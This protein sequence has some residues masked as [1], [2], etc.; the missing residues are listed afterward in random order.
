MQQSAVGDLIERRSVRLRRRDPSREIFG[1]HRLSVEGHVREAIAVE[2]CGDSQE[3]AGAISGEIKLGG[4]AVH[5][6]DLA[7]ELRY[8]EDVENARGRQA[9]VHR[10]ADRCYET[11]DARDVLI[12]INEEPLPV[13][14]DDFYLERLH[15]GAQ[16]LGR[17]EL[18]R[19]D[20]RNAAKEEHD[21]CRYGP[22]EKLEPTR[23]GP[24]RRVGG[25][26]VRSAIPPGN[27]ERAQ[28]RRHDNRKHDGE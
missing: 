1:G 28:D 20:P 8:P 13:E 5:R 27:G 19:A 24:V 7:A 21:E 15:V 12:R 2:M 23:F 14:G 3:R 25:A 22:D 18:M 11:I 17:I 4:H 6:V 16:R 26:L 9:K 10:G